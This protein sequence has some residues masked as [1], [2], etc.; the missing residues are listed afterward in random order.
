MISQLK[1]SQLADLDSTHLLRI[2]RPYVI[3]AD[4]ITAE[5]NSHGWNF[6]VAGNVAAH[7]F[8]SSYDGLA[9][10]ESTLSVP[11]KKLV[12]VLWRFKGLGRTGEWAATVSL[13]FSQFDQEK[14]KETG[15]SVGKDRSCISIPARA[16]C[17]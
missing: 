8:L 10:T 14:L 11:E 2:P 13:G 4:D 16:K 3:V 9:V 12:F 17:W 15:M 5:A 7:L 6:R 1:R